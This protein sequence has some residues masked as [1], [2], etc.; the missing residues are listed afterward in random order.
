MGLT[1]V[2]F[3][4]M[5]TGARLKLTSVLKGE[6]LFA[7]QVSCMTSPVGD[8]ISMRRHRLFQPLSEDPFKYKNVPL[9]EDRH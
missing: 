5:G 6:E 1:T 4:A 3:V 9:L 7:K 8:F 2:A